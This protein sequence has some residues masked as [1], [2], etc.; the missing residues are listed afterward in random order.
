MYKVNDIFSSLQG[1][2]HHTGRAATFVRFAGCNLRC[3]FC[4]TDFTHYREMSAEEIVESVKQY[5]TRFVVLTGGEPSLQIDDTLITALHEAG[6]YIAVETN[7]TRLL[8]ESIDWVTV[9]PK[10][11]LTTTS[12]PQIESGRVNEIKVVFDGTA[13]D[14]L[15]SIEHL[16]KEAE[17]TRDSFHNL[18]SPL[19]FLQPCDVGDAQRNAE[20]TRQC[21]EYIMQHPCWQLSLQTHKLANFK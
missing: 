9:S 18:P 16:E 7:G 11:P 3:P 20:I 10:Q 14:I 12:L 4:D 17:Y 8:P 13:S 5:T 1:E 19:L 15:L 2:G 21:I 6:F